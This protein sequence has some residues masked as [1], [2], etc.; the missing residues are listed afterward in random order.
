MAERRYSD[1]EVREIFAR[2]TEVQHRNAAARTG[3]EG[4]S[5]VQLEEIAREAGIAPELVSAAA[6][7]LDQPQPA[8]LPT[9]L[10]LPVG[11]GRSVALPRALSDQEW[12]R[13]VVRLRDTFNARGIIETQGRFRT[14]RNGN[15]QVLVEPTDE[16]DRVRF[17]TVKGDTRALVSA[18]LAMSAVSAVTVLVASFT[19]AE[20]LARALASLGSVGVIGVSL[21]VAGLLRL[22]GWRRVR[23]RQM[24]EL[25]DQL[26]REIN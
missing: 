11:V 23:Q 21:T 3:S 1:D 24:D 26:L 25:A 10:G 17:R 4:M 16:G 12:E 15:L 20:Q 9:V 22:P 6:R 7:E 2:A 8:P 5:L 18:G 14:W 19:G 13:L